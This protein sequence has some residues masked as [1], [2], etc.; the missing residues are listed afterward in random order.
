MAT[1]TSLIIFASIFIARKRKA[2]KNIRRFPSRS[3]SVGALH[4]GK[5]ALHRLL[6]Y[7]EAHENAASLQRAEAELKDIL[8]EEQP[9]FVKMQRTVA[10]LEISRK[11]EDAVEILQKAAEKARTGK[12]HEAYETEMLL[13]EMLIYTGDFDRA[14]DCKCLKH[15]EISDAR[16]PLYKAIIH[17][18]LGRKEQAKKCWADF[19]D[20]QEHF[21]WPPSLKESQILDKVTTA[22]EEFE[23]V[24]QMLKDDIHKAQAK[25]T[26]KY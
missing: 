19:K 2:K 23:K 11:E 12:K 18:M 21:E 26:M 15:E 9:D 1:A 20:I 14:F 5:L 16:R 6:D 24:V 25:K 13:V 17:V 4:G 3:L 22:F 7:Y 8:E 10:K